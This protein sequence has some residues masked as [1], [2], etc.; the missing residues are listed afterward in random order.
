MR[1][2]WGGDGVIIEDGVKDVIRRL[3]CC[4]EELKRWSRSAFPNNRRMI[5]G[6]LK[7]LTKKPFSTKVATNVTEIEHELEQIWHREE[8]FGGRGLGWLG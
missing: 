2:G 4:R 7:Q 8:C 1:R 3:W 5:D 6:L